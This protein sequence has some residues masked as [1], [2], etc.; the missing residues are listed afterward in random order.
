VTGKKSFDTLQLAAGRFILSKGEVSNIFE[1]KVGYGL[2]RIEEKTPPT[3]RSFKE[4]KEGITAK[5]KSQKRRDLADHIKRDL[6]KNITITINQ[7]LLK[8]YH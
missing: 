5:L 1:T 8:T 2:L 3:F 4:V 7:P 6:R